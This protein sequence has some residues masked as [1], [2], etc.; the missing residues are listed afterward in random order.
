VSAELPLVGVVSTGGT[1][2]NTVGGRVAIEDVIGDVPQVHEHARFEVVATSRVGSSE[3]GLDDWAEIAHAAQR[4][5]DDDR[6]TGVIVT[7]GTYT[8]EETSYLLHLTLKTEKP[9]VVVSSQ[10]RHGTIGNDGDRNLVEAVRVATS[11]AARGHGVLVVLNEEIHS[12]RDVLKTSG[13]PGGFRSGDLGI[14]GYVD[15]GDVAFY[16]TPLR[17]HTT[18]SEL[19]VEAVAG[20]PRVDVLYSVVGADAATVAP[21]VAA[22]RPAGIVVAGFSFDGTP[23]PAQ[24]EALRSAAEDGVAVV[25]TNRGLGG[26]VPRHLPWTKLMQEPFISGDTLAPQKARILLA[27]ALTRTQSTDLA[28]LQR[29]FD[30]Y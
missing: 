10:R 22:A 16:R 15:E 8:N 18:Q 5:A 28:E 17:R 14:L 29:F 3:L 4:L 24:L 30:E 6:V 12:A 20:M 27:L 1:I 11:P 21:L 7:H 9:V 2:A 23:P 25:L 19:P 26:R 13:R